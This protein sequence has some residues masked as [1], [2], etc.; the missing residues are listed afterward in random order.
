MEVFGKLEVD[1]V[2]GYCAQIRLEVFPMEVA[3]LI[4][5]LESMAGVARSADTYVVKNITD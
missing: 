2:A 4:A 1:P 3:G 5:N